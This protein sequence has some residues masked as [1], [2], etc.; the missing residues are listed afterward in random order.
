MGFLDNSIIILYLV[1][2]VGIGIYANTRQKS[3]DDYYVAGRRLGAGSIMVLWVSSWIGGASIIGSAETAYDLGITGIWYVGTMAFGCAL[4]AL[5]FSGLVKKVGDK[6]KNITFPELIEARYDGR[7]RT[8]ATIS[9][10]LA[11]IAY[12]AGQLAAIGAIL[13]TLL[14]WDPLHCFIL[15][16]VV[17]ILYT[18][19]GGLLAVTY[20]DWVQ[21]SLLI[22]AVT[23]VGLPV[24][25]KAAGGLAVIKATIPAGHWDLGA[26]GWAKIIGLFVTITFS[27]FTAMDSYTRMYAARDTSAAKKGTWLAL[28][29]LG[30]IAV[31]ATFLGL[32]ARSLFPALAGGGAEAMATLIK[33]LFPIG[34]KGLMLVGIL[35]AIMSTADICIL[36][37]SANL[38]EDIYHRFI[39]PKATDAFLRKFGMVMS[40]FIGTASAFMAWRMMSIIDILYVAFTINSA[41]L[42]IPTI[43]AFYWKKANSSAAFWSMSLSLATVLLWYAGGSFAWAPIFS[44]DPV[45][46]G[47]IVS[48]VIFFAVCLTKKTPQD[49]L[50]KIDEFYVL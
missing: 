18:T 25:W 29:A 6:L 31:S 26:W 7:S 17:V 34:I 37:C 16:A 3:K 45:W 9:T 28:V 2:M 40:L 8:V 48:A 44:V 4:F 42:F 13:H 12:T 14:G 21:F 46:P 38:T 36:T 23:I 20:T 15:G 1:G 49:E 43:A 5:L 10:I 11:Y 19:L 22:L 35:A 24:A 47:L 50:A 33:E 32:A 39:N 30:V 41:G 27:F